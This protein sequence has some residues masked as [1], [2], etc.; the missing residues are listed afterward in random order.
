M[1]L[2]VYLLVAGVALTSARHPRDVNRYL[3]QAQVESGHSHGDQYSGQDAEGRSIDHRRSANSNRQLPYSLAPVIQIQP[4]YSDSNS[5]NVDYSYVTE[6]DHVA[7]ISEKVDSSNNRQNEFK[8]RTNA[9]PT[10]T[11]EILEQTT[12]PFNEN[13][14]RGQV[15]VEGRNI[16]SNY[17]ESENGRRESLANQRSPNMDPQMRY[18][19]HDSQPNVNN[20]DSANTNVMHVKTNR[21]QAAETTHNDRNRATQ[22]TSDRHPDS[23]NVS[24]NFSSR[25]S[26]DRNREEGERDRAPKEKDEEEVPW[27]WGSEPEPKAKSSEPNDLDDRAAFDGSACASGYVKVQGTCVEKH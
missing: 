13:R 10:K 1:V 18:A 8:L 5:P 25:G 12:E 19:S 9:Y 20:D 27:V 21:G 11:N 14:Q 6:S 24:T 2:T 7:L 17:G 3:A 16:N 15:N 26:A 4:V 23:S 22:R